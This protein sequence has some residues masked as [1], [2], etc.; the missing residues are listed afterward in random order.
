MNLQLDESPLADFDEIGRVAPGE[1]GMRIAHPRA[2]DRDGTLIDQTPRLVL[3]SD[4]ARADQLLY[5]QA[6]DLYRAF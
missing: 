2:V 5:Q 4:N 1:R 6:P 3:G